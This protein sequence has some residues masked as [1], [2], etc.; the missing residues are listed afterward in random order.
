MPLTHVAKGD[1]HVQAHNQERDVIEGIR[2]LE[3]PDFVSANAS[4]T[5]SQLKDRNSDIGKLVRG[6][7]TLF[8]VEDYGAV[9]DGTTATPTDFVSVFS[10]VLV[11]AVLVGGGIV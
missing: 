7:F 11:A 10:V 3:D 1:A 9:A 5:L 6:W 8:P 4:F 2:T